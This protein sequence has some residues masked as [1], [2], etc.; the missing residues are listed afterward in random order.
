MLKANDET[1]GKIVAL[2]TWVRG[3]N[4]GTQLQAYSLL[5]LLLRKGFQTTILNDTVL[6]GTLEKKNQDNTSGENAPVKENA[7]KL[8][9]YLNKA[10]KALYVLS[11]KNRYQGY[12]KQRKFDEFTYRRKEVFDQFKQDFLF[13]QP[14]IRESELDIIGQ[15]YDIYICGSD[16]IWTYHSN[17]Q[18]YYYYLGFTDSSK[19]RI[20][21][22]P[23]IGAEVPDKS[24]EFLGSLIRHFDSLSARDIFGKEMMSVLSG[25]NIPVVVDPVLLQSKEQWMRMLGIS[26]RPEKYMLC[27][28]LGEHEWYKKYVKDLAKHLGLKIKWI[29][30][31]ASQLEYADMKIVYGPKE[32]VEVICNA[33]YVCTDS[34]HGTLFS[35]LFNKQMTVLSRYTDTENKQNE[36][37]YS[38]F[39]MLNMDIRMIRGKKFEPGDLQHL[40]YEPIDRELKK[41]REQSLEYLY[42]A[43]DL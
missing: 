22:A 30:V 11:N 32:F 5:H 17:A 37:F 3:V 29:L 28:L 7:S 31:H 19:K 33:A 43:I 6:S 23:V 20:A 39:N 25:Q 41:A 15:T 9:Y 24:R 34:Y 13:L 36:R 14:P 38:V 16:Q 35:I 27:Y 8:R 40:F 42:S 26:K 1:K 10:K 4:Y 21:Y 2:V 18:C 12:K